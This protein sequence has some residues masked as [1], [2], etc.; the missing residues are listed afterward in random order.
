MSGL[1]PIN[2][3]LRIFN[4]M[5]LEGFFSSS[6]SPGAKAPKAHT[7]CFIVDHLEHIFSEGGHS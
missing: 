3:T 5:S 7:C 6:S 1:Y 2:Y 4:I